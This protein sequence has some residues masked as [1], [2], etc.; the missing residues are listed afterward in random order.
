MTPLP[1]RGLLLG[2]GL[3]DRLVFRR[4][5][6]LLPAAG[7][8]ADVEAAGPADRA[9]LAFEVGIKRVIP[10]PRTRDENQQGREDGHRANRASEEHG[11][12]P[13]RQVGWV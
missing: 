11:F 12:F 4:Q 5:R 7:G 1:A 13:A 6:S 9:P 10:C 8:L 2:V 3:E